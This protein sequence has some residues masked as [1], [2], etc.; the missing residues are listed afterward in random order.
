LVISL[1]LRRVVSAARLEKK[2]PTVLSLCGAV[3]SK[4]LNEVRRC[5]A[6]QRYAE[7]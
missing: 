6:T 1:A 7:N 2:K 5:S 3:R 4:Y